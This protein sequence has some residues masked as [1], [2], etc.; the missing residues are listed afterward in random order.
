MIE[1]KDIT[2]DFPEPFDDE[3]LFS[4][5]NRFYMTLGLESAV[6]F[7]RKYL[8]YYNKKSNLTYANI[9][10][11]FQNPLESFEHTIFP[12]YLSC[13]SKESQLEI[14]NRLLEGESMSREFKIVRRP[15]L[16]V[17]GMRYCSLCAKEDI[18]KYGMPY[19]HTIHQMGGFEV[20][21]YH[22]IYLNESKCDHYYI[23]TASDIQSIKMAPEAESRLARSLLSFKNLNREILDACILDALRKYKLLDKG[24]KLSRDGIYYLLEQFYGLEFL[25][26][27]GIESLEEMKWISGF[28]NKD[29]IMTP[30]QYL[31]ILT[32]LEVDVSTIDEVGDREKDLV[33]EKPKRKCRNTYCKVWNLEPIYKDART[34]YY[35][36]PECN[37]IFTAKDRI[38]QYGKL[39][40]K[41]IRDRYA[42]DGYSIRDI[43]EETGITRRAVSKVINNQIDPLVI[44]HKTELYRVSVSGFQNKRELSLEKSGIYSHLKKYDSEWLD[45]SFPENT[46][47]LYPDETM[48]A[49]DLELLNFLKDSK[50]QWIKSGE[51]LSKTFF[52]RYLGFYRY[53]SIKS[54]YPLTNA[55]TLDHIESWEEYKKRTG[56]A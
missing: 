12:Y 2:L 48:R 10:N 8:N 21:P 3:F 36:C 51:R 49:K 14:Q 53:H 26:K 6:K 27:V 4:I 41:K 44:D 25:N 16:V 30:F 1:L 55:F 29:S 47:N 23:L 40:Y 18:K 17:N 15:G 39:F 19:F 22:G 11:K 50:K 42:I 28:H 45:A 35:R 13:Y 34:V 43:S 37:C 38:L 9:L 33:E 56:K 46:I 20:C 31:L 24:D 52:S 7:N 5:I 32:A 54:H